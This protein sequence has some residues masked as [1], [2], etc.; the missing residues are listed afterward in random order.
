MATSVTTEISL[1]M[2]DKLCIAQDAFQK[3]HTICFWF[4]REDLIVTEENLHLV[5][6]G[7]RENGTWETYP[8]PSHRM[9]KPGDFR[10]K[11]SQI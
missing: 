6:K 9:K 1:T 8:Q 10:G 11:K 7:L 2:K 4:M 3:F 5:V